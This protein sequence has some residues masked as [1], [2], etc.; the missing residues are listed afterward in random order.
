MEA[1]YVVVPAMLALLVGLGASRSLARL[2]RLALRRG[3]SAPIHDDANSPQ[4]D[5]A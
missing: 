2:V 4:A 5:R 3:S 1:L